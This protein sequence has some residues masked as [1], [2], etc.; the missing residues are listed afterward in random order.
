MAKV[1]AV[2]GMV[3]V[4]TTAVMVMVMVGVGMMVT[5][6]AVGQTLTLAAATSAVAI[7]AVAILGEATFELRKR[8]PQTRLVDLQAKMQSHGRNRRL[9]KLALQQSHRCKKLLL[10]GLPLLLLLLLRLLMR[11]LL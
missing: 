5:A 6:A 1:A 2:A 10:R 3:K 7:L 9:V 4:A 8:R 11:L